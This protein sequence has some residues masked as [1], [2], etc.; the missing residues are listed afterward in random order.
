MTPLVQVG[1]VGVHAVMAPAVNPRYIR[2]DELPVSVCADGAN[3]LTRVSAARAKEL[4]LYIEPGKT[5]YPLAAYVGKDLG[6]RVLWEPSGRG[7]YGL[8]APES[9]LPKGYRGDWE[10]FG[11]LVLDGQ[12]WIQGPRDPYPGAY[13][14]TTALQDHEYRIAEAERYF[15]AA[16][17]PG[18]VLPSDDLKRLG[19][20]LG[21]LA[22]LRHGP[23]EIIAQAC[24]SGNSGHMAELT[25]EA[26]N[27]LGLPDCS[28]DGSSPGGPGGVSIEI[29]IG[30]HTRIVDSKGRPRP[31]TRDEIAQAGEAAARAAGLE[32]GH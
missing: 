13:L 14:S 25:V 16:G 22:V 21:D 17:L 12:A 28:R 4:G 27:M 3:G 31:G 5:E 29:L 15:D 9:G 2:L 24:D 30:S 19:V 10:A 20:G 11:W 8:D 1:A 23:Y 32:I 7:A 6:P 26:C 18:F